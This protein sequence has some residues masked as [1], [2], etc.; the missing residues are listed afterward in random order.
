MYA[1]VLRQ[2]SSN[3]VTGK[4]FVPDSMKNS[5]RQQAEPKSER[6]ESRP[7]TEQT[8]REGSTLLRIYSFYSMEEISR[9]AQLV[10]EDS[11]FESVI[12]RNDAAGIYYLIL[13]SGQPGSPAFYAASAAASEFG[14]PVRAS[15]N[16]LYYYDEHYTMMIRS[17]ALQILR[18]L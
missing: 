12:Y 5:V 4:P 11:G 7:D 2:L 8:G 18:S 15:R 6:P 9:L 1:D 10:P 14:R 16:T 3:I 13:S 17:R